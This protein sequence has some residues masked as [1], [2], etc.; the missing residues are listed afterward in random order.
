MSIKY[1]NEGTLSCDYTCSIDVF[2]KKFGESDHRKRLIS[3][4]LPG[5]LI[6]KKA[7]IKTLYIGGSFA[8]NKEKPNDI[9]GVFDILECINTGG[10][11][12]SF[13][14]KEQRQ[15]SLDLSYMHT[16]TKLT[17]ETH[18]NFF[19]RGRDGEKRGLILLDLETLME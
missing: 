7:G 11:L 19:R 2:K 3:R 5:L 14:E 18:L 13:L 1:T 15:Y 10:D 6:L 8:P 16:P 12:E 9:D 4:V 17:A